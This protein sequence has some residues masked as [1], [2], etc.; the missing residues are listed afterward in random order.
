[1][2]LEIEKVSALNYNMNEVCIYSYDQSNSLISS[3]QLS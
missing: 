2:V 1:M 3:V